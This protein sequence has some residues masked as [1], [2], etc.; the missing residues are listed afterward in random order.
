V[1]AVCQ[2]FLGVGDKQTAKAESLLRTLEVQREK[3][4]EKLVQTEALNSR[5]LAL[6]DGETRLY[7]HLD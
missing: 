6:R 2:E 7:Q 4:S 3:N 5:H 1:P